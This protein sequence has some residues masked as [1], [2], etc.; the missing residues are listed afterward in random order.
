[1]PEIEFQFV[2]K[3]FARSLLYLDLIFAYRFC[4]FWA[5]EVFV[6]KTFSLN[7]PTSQI[8]LKTSSPVKSKLWRAP[9]F[10][11]AA[12]LA[13]TK[14]FKDS[15]FSPLR[16]C[17]SVLVKLKSPRAWR[18]SDNSFNLIQATTKHIVFLV[19]IWWRYPQHL[20]NFQ[21]NVLVGTR[22]PAQS[23]T[24]FYLNCASLKHYQFVMFLVQKNL[25]NSG[26]VLHLILSR[27]A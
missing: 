13:R 27:S 3:I 9:Y 15:K 14:D 4:T 10:S 5:N 25:L 23:I 20:L 18:Q 26:P 8:W 12:E 24:N 7:F 16:F 6:N 1:M 19:F 11:L 21:S 2:L 17:I 22:S